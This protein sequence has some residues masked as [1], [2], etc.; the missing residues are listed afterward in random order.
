MHVLSEKP[1]ASTLEQGEKLLSAAHDNNVRYCVG[2]MKRYDDGVQK[3]K[4]MLDELIENNSLGAIKYVRAQCFMGNSYCNANGHIV[5]KEIGEYPDKGWETSPQWLPEN[6][7]K[8]YA[9]YINTYSHLTNL[10]YFLFEKK[11]KVDFSKM[12]VNAAQVAVLDYDTFTTTLETGTSSN[13]GWDESV[14]IYFEHGKLTLT[15][16][17]AL[18]KNVPAKV[19]LYRAGKYQE[20]IE[21]QFQWNWAFRNQAES[22]INDILSG[23]KSLIEAENALLDL[24][25]IEEIWSKDVC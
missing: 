20:V 14:E 4:F 1:M 15:L 10:L 13:S 9:A 18:L 12:N 24:E 7:A 23:K 2:Y 6:K 16:P 21:P 22:F 3:A 8:E 11:P 17:P 25:L 19:K 5:T